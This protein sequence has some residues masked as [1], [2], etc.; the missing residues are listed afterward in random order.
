MHR[1]SSSALEPAARAGEGKFT[2]CDLF[3]LIPTYRQYHGP[4][5]PESDLWRNYNCQ[6]SANRTDRSPSRSASDLFD[7]IVRAPE[8]A[9]PWIRCQVCHLTA[10]SWGYCCSRNRVNNSRARTIFYT[11]I[12]ATGSGLTAERAPAG[13]EIESNRAHKSEPRA[14]A[15]CAYEELPNVG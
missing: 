5:E 1:R 12:H 2:R 3:Y 7:F 14:P 11:A 6:S 13:I 8:S 15:L 4:I 10:A 9:R